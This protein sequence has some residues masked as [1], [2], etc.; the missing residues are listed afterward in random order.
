M[1][2]S[3]GACDVSAVPRGPAPDPVLG[4]ILKALREARGLTQ[5][6][7]APLAQITTGTLSKVETGQTSCGWST[8]RLIAKAL[9]VSMAELG[10]AID[11]EDR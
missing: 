6:Q 8:V 3:A 4:P 2:Y 10:A 9:D 11:A 5:E 1:D 7:L